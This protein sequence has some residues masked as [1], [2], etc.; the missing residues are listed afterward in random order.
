[1]CQLYFVEKIKGET[2]LR[3]VAISRFGAI[4]DWPAGFFDQA[5]D[6]TERILFAASMKAKKNLAKE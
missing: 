6:E 5:Q 4:A 1:M 2:A 3:E